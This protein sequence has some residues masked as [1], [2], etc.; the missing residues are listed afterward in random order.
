MIVVD[1]AS[2]EPRAEAL[3]A[4]TGVR[5]ERNPENLRFPRAPATVRRRSPAARRWSSSTTTRW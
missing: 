1:D 5:F 4:V 2:P 3:A